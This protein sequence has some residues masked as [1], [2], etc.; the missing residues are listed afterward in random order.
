LIDS[1]SAD[2]TVG[3]PT[4]P[5]DNEL[6]GVAADS[7]TDIWAVGYYN[8]GTPSAPLYQTLIEH[9]DG[10]GWQAVSS[11]DTTTTQDNVLTQVAAV[12][13]SDL[14]SV[15]S[16]DIVSD[17]Q[18]MSQTLV[19]GTPVPSTTSISSSVNPSVAG[20]PLTLTATVNATSSFTPTGTVTFTSNGTALAGCGAV[21]LSTEQ[22]QC[23]ATFATTGTLSLQALYSGDDNFLASSAT[24]FQTVNSAPTTTTLRVSSTSV[25]V[26]ESVAVTATVAPL[27]PGA[28]TPTGTVEFDDSGAVVNGCGAQSLASAVATCFA[29]FSTPGIHTLRA[30]YDGDASFIT[31]SSA[32]VAV[33]VGTTITTLASSAN[34]S[35]AGD[36]VTYTATVI[37]QVPGDATP[38]GTVEF[39]D[40][41][42]VVNGCGAQSLASGVATCNVVYPLSNTHTIT[43]VYS[44]NAD[45][46]AS[47]SA[48][49]TQT[50]SGGTLALSASTAPSAGTPFITD[51]SPVMLGSGQFEVSTGQ[52]G[53]LQVE[54]NRG[55][56]SGWSVTA[57]LESD[58]AN[59]QPSGASADNTIPADFLTWVPDVTAAVDGASMSGMSAGDTSTLSNTTAVALCSAAQGFGGSDYDCGASLSLSIPRY[60]AAGTYLAT[61]DIVVTSN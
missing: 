49:L 36:P 55:T 9:N 37:P 16:A 17:A 46:L 19:E 61:L 23:T 42:A 11:P 40:S 58:F 7:A 53:T 31:S 59:E 27:P 47:T 21:S 8:A 39:D 38:T 52:L 20:Q 4:T 28:G 13:S 41:G 14:W 45:Y 57:Q 3:S 1:S 29:S 54:D 44:G 35:V 25:A 26:G 5:T 24:L 48:D 30:V 33:T 6:L 60:V 50:V 10:T 22:A 51:L 2:T 18:T 32:G 34:P 12:S 43:A 56:E 15:G